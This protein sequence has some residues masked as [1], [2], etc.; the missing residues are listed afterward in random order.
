MKEISQNRPHIYTK[1]SEQENSETEKLME[2]GASKETKWG[3]TEDKVLIWDTKNTLKL[4]SVDGYHN[5]VNI[6]NHA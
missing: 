6:L 1:C 2:A 5:Y 3:L 4:D